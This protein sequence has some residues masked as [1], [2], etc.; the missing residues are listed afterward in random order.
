MASGVTVNDEV[1]K[2][3]NN[4]KGSQKYTFKK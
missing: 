1:T 2:V 3:F 4:V